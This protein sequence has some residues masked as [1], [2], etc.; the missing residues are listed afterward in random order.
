MKLGLS[1]FNGLNYVL[2]ED[3][4]QKVPTWNAFKIS[5]LQKKG[6]PGSASYMKA[7]AAIAMTAASLYL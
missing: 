3:D 5:P 4:A 7:S 2:D 1:W 6:E